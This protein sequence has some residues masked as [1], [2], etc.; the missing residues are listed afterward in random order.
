MKAVDAKTRIYIDF[1]KENNEEGSNFKVDDSVRISKY[2]NVFGKSYVPNWSEEVF[3][4]NKVK[5]LHCQHMLLVILIE[6]KMLEL[7]TNKNQ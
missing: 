1:N 4:I 7:F 2:K 5:I 6:K 3:V